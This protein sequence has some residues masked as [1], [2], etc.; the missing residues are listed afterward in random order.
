MRI[1][2]LQHGVLSQCLAYTLGIS[3]KHSY[4]TCHIDNRQMRYRETATATLDTK[5]IFTRP[6]TKDFAANI[7]LVG[8]QSI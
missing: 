1:M 4:I 6:I 7:H 3:T 5:A 2:L 8:M